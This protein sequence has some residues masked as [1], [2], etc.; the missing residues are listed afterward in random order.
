MTHPVN[1]VLGMRFNVIAQNRSSLLFTIVLVFSGS[2]GPIAY[3]HV[4]CQ[5]W[6]LLLNRPVYRLN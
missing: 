5:D 1:L 6:F 4:R 3:W 2:I